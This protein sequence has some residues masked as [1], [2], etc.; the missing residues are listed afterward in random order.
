MLEEPITVLKDGK[1]IKMSP[2]EAAMRRQV[3]KALNE[4]NLPAIKE[5]ISLALTHGLVAPPD[6]ALGGIIIIPKT[7]SEELYRYIFSYP[8]PPVAHILALLENHYDE[9]E[10]K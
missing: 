2:I 1:A 7:L 3:Q 4:K 5:V 9:L 8:G 10:G 6:K